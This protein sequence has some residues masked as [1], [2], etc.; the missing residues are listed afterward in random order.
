MILQRGSNRRVE[1]VQQMY[2][3]VDKVNV[4]SVFSFDAFV[5]D[6]KYDFIY[7]RSDY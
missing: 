4:R 1:N 7:Y 6:F 2:A 5:F 3:L